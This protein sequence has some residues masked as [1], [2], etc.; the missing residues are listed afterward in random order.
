M[1]YDWAY[2]I[3]HRALLE[4]WRIKIENFYSMLAPFNGLLVEMVGSCFY[5]CKFLFVRMPYI[6]PFK[7]FIMLLNNGMSSHLFCHYHS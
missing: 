4:L 2:D 7:V 5:L 6:D 3:K 1:L